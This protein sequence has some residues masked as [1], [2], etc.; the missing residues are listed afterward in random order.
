MTARRPFFVIN[1][2]AAGGRARKLIPVI[3][4]LVRARDR[5]AE[6]A[7]TNDVGHAS[8]L[9][10]AAAEDGFAPV[11]GVGGDGTLHE[12]TNGLLQARRTAPLA[13]VPSGTGND[14]VRSLGLPRQLTAAVALAWDGAEKTID[15]AACGGR[16]FLNVGGVGFD[17]RAARAASEFPRFLRIGVVPYVAGVLHELIVNATD[18]L[19]LH[20]DDQV[21][22]RRL[23]MVAI[24]NL[25]YYASGMMICPGASPFDGLLDV[26]IVGRM[27]RR[28][29]LSVLPKVF[30]G[31]HREHPLVEFHKTR[32]LRI[33]GLARSE[34]QLDGELLSIDTVVFEC[35]P[36]ALQVMVPTPA[37]SG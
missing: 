10:R 12:I 26:C 22:H 19:T 36:A 23:L 33:E 9:A 21:I 15:V 7:V 27:A 32:A 29:V 28:E 18:E 31:G 5:S 2:S 11:V 4:D 6:I 17:A 3:Q 25:P 30:S 37:R 13:A 20:L 24:A 35:V 14:F 34:V 16:Y 8:D 1:P